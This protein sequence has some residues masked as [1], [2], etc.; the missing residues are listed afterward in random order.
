[1]Y[2][3]SSYTPKNLYQFIRDELFFNFDLT[4]EDKD[5]KEIYS[6]LEHHNYSLP[7]SY[8]SLMTI[9]ELQEQLIEQIK[10]ECRKLIP[11]ID[12]AEM[13]RNEIVGGNLSYAIFEKNHR[14]IMVF[15]WVE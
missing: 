15:W 2:H 5:K 1:M 3:L 8:H 10:E 14:L 7:F 13:I 6:Q 11:F 12:F 4:L 9:H